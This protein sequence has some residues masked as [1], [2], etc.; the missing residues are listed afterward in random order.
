MIFG[1]IYFAKVFLVNVMF[2][3][4][5]KFKMASL[6]MKNSISQAS[7]HFCITITEDQRHHGYR[8]LYQILVRYIHSLESTAASTRYQPPAST[9]SA[10]TSTASAVIA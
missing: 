6:L 4:I 8:E 1:F 7:V 3:D 2:C 5:S 9:T 10:P